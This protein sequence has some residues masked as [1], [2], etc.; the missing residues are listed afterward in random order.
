MLINDKKYIKNISLYRRNIFILLLSN[1]YF[2]LYR[3]CFSINIPRKDFVYRRVT[4][5]NRKPNGTILKSAFNPR[6]KDNGMLSVDWSAL[7]TPEKSIKLYPDAWLVE[8]CVAKIRDIGADVR[9][10]PIS[11]NKAHSYISDVNKIMS[12]ADKIKK[13]AK[14]INT[15]SC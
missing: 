7:T 3:L 9:Y 8:I 11:N 1:V 5:N 2:I 6:V 4:V 13:L 14:R 12:A 10:A 15:T